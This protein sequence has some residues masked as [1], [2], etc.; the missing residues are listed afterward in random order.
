MRSMIAA[1]VA[2]VAYLCCLSASSA[3]QIRVINDYGERVELWQFVKADWDQPPLRLLRNG[4]GYVDL[5]RPGKYFLLLRDSAQRDR[6]I[7]WKDLHPI[8]EI[9]HNAS[10]RLNQLFVSETRIRLFTIWNRRARRWERREVK[11]IV[12][13]PVGPVLYVYSGGQTYHLDDFVNRFKR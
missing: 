13:K 3:Q 8:Y 6:D 12:K 5:T 2:I 11:E 10:L 1:F 4:D 7:G 9:D